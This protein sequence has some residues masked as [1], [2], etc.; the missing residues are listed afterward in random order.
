MIYRRFGRTNWQLSEIGYGMWGMG[1]WKESDDIQSM[2]SLNLAVEKG[3]NFFDT[4]WGYG[5]GHSERLLGKLLQSHPDKKLYT[6]SKLPPK[7]FKWPAK[8]HYTF[9]ESYPAVHIKAYTEKTLKNIGREQIDL[10]QFHTWDDGWT[11]QEEWQRTVE[12]LKKEGK[13]AA[14]GISMNRWEPENGIVTLETGLIDAV[15]VIYNIFDQA[16][17]D[18][19]FPYCDANDI[20]VIARVPFDE[21]TLTG[22]ITRETTFQEGDW[23]GTYFVP[24]NLNA[25]ADRADLLRPLIPKDTDMASV[26]LRF[27]LENKSVG[28]IIPGMRKQKNV[29]VNI[30]CSDGKP[31]DTELYAKLKT[32]RWDRKP[33]SWSQ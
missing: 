14:M 29:I 7:N 23:R 17:E 25:S 33:T 27:I 6:A 31:M 12:D 9:E 26:A 13:I 24:E 22:N 19:L 8:P 30:N 3:V 1:G 21:G 10:M 32:H 20:A 15:Q 28:T 11:H 18:S 2:E 16:P 4:A 5:E